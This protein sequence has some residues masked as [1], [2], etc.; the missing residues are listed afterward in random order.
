MNC[1]LIFLRISY[2]NI[3]NDKIKILIVIKTSN[4]LII[5]L[6]KRTILYYIKSE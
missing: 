5:K 2:S 6:K 1:R 3:N 4:I